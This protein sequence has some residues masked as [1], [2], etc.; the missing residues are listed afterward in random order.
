MEKPAWQVT[1]STYVID[2]PHMRMRRDSLLLPDGTELPEYFV[3]ESEGFTI[4]C[5]ITTGGDVVM[6]EQ[7]RYGNDAINL[8]LPAGTLAPGEDALACAQRELLEE[9]GYT[10]PRWEQIGAPFTEP[11]RSKAHMYA[12]LAL[13]ASETA[14]Q[15][16]DPSE[17]LEVRVLPLER[18]RAMLR[19][20]AI[21]SLACTMTLYRAFDVLDR[22][23][24]S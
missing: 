13:D 24:A 1:A 8:E 19:D 16:L 15:Q 4:V 12:Y 3:R 9:T 21:P 11:S 23:T 6:I 20:D 18:V 2:S 14:P 17:C 22:R 10:A 7:Y 5:A